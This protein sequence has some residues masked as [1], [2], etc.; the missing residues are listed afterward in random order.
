MVAPPLM[1]NTTTGGKCVRPEAHLGSS[2]LG[3][4]PARVDGHHESLLA[5]QLHSKAAGEHVHGRLETET[6][7]QSGPATSPAL[8][9]VHQEHQRLKNQLPTG[10]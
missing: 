2:H 8:V 7:N 3:L 6:T 9:P 4:D 1:S 10:E 5:L